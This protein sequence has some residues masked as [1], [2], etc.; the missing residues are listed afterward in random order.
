MSGI[1]TQFNEQRGFVRWVGHNP[2]TQE[3][4]AAFLLGHLAYHTEQGAI[5]TTSEHVARA[6]RVVLDDLAHEFPEF[7]E[8]EVERES[9]IGGGVFHANELIVEGVKRAVRGE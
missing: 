4:Y 5:S 2:D 6:L 9:D 1:P 7:L 3:T 8:T